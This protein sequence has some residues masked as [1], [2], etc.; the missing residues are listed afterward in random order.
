MFPNKETTTE[1]IKKKMNSIEKGK[2]KSFDFDFFLTMCKTFEL[3]AD[4]VLDIEPKYENHDVDFICS[5][6]GLNP[7][8]V[9][10]LHQL[11]RN[12][13]VEIDNAESGYFIDSFRLEQLLN[14][15]TGII[16]LKIINLLL[17]D[18]EK[19]QPS[20]FN[21][22]HSLYLLCMAKPTEVIGHKLDLS[23]SDSDNQMVRLYPSDT[24]CI[25]DENGIWYGADASELLKQK[26]RK[27]LELDI[28]Q[29]VIQMKSK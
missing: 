27:Q 12:A 19:K 8:A 11:N 6:T 3:S 25:K 18:T 9:K 2:M 24:I 15:Q 16:Y 7:Q 20:K 5:Y 13:N 23:L 14:K 26:A 4:Y 1:N 28:D 29:L 17:Q 10:Y 21:I 22:L